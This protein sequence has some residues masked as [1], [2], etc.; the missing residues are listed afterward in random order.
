MANVYTEPWFL[1]A[2]LR[3]A[4]PAV[5]LAQLGTLTQP[6]VVTLLREQRVQLFS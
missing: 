3:K 6:L 5:S 2:E 1:V 4:H